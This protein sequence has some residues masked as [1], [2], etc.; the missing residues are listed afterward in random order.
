M[1]KYLLASLA[2][3][4]Q[5]LHAE[6]AYVWE[7][8]LTLES[9]HNFSGGI[10]KGSAELA[11]LDVTLS[12]DTAAA[13]WWDKGTLFIYGLA[14]YGK[15]PA[16]YTGGAQ[17][18]SNIAAEANTAKVYEFWYQHQLLD[19]HL[20][21]LTGL[22]DYN[23]TFYSLES[24]GL[25]TDPSFGIGPDTSQVTPSIFPT[26]AWTLQARYERD[27][28]YTLAAVYDGVPGKPEQ[29][30]G[31]H[32]RFGKKDGLFKALEVGFTEQDDYKI[33]LGL[34]N[35]TA[36]QENPVDGSINDNNHGLYL[37]GEKTIFTDASVFFQFGQADDSKNQL[38]RYFGAGIQIK[39]IAQE[40][41]ALGLAL[42]QAQNGNP[43]LAANPESLRSETAMEL[44][45]QIPW[46]QTCSSQFSLYRI[47]NPAMDPNLRDSTAAGVRLVIGF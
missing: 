19:G 8:A 47:H 7:N 38:G 21:L 1:T 6:A 11:N 14:D 32:I 18:T 41:D 17:G 46:T 27:A 42:A 23:S 12:I 45:Y 15:D 22:H 24:A 36:E 33:G 3:L 39:N 10:K 28:F 40:G 20:K 2:L 9:I 29:P 37:I 13:G 34:W 35:L 5:H 16:D 26:T 43:F 4:S 30:R 44:S 31:T 25:F